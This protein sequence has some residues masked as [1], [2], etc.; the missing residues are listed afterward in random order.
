MVTF[1]A[2][3][4]PSHS[5]LTRLA[6]RQRELQQQREPCEVGQENCEDKGVQFD[7]VEEA[8]ELS[9]EDLEDIEQYG[10]IVNEAEENR[11]LDL[12]YVR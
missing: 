5:Y 12:A 11:P 8:S 7:N 1:L 10:G 4:E 2:N 3:F 6:A 9:T